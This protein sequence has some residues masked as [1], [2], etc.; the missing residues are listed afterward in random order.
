MR[1]GR[2]QGT[3][4]SYL[5]RHLRIKYRQP[6]DLFRGSPYRTWCETSR[7]CSGGQGAGFFLSQWA[8]STPLLSYHNRFSV[9]PTCSVNEETVE[10]SIDVQ[11]SIPEN[12]TIVPTETTQ[13]RHPKWGVLYTPPHNLSGSEQNPSGMVRIWSEWSEFDWNVISVSTQ[14]NLTW[15]QIDSDQIPTK[16]QPFRAESLGSSGIP[17]PVRS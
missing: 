17:I 7:A 13:N 4:L 9:L 12:L 15:T 2:T 8:N 1:K 16:F 3:Q 10:P 11:N 5:I 14:P 6:P